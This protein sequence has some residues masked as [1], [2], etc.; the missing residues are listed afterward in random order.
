MDFTRPSTQKPTK[1]ASGYNIFYKG[2]TQRARRREIAQRLY[3]ERVLHYPPGSHPN[4]CNK[5]K[6]IGGKWKDL[7]A[8]ARELFSIRSKDELEMY[9]VRKGLWLAEDR[10]SKPA[11]SSEPAVAELSPRKAKPRASPDKDGNAPSMSHHAQ[12][13]LVHFLL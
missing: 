12:Y 8:H 4:P 6:L 5:T 11:S 3:A 13:H 1:P 9:H 7:Q 10:V 2:A